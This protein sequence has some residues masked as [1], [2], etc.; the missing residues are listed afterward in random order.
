MSKVLRHF[1]DYVV[2]FLS[3]NKKC[4]RNVRILA[5]AQRK[6]KVIKTKTMPVVT[7]HVEGCGFVTADVATEIGVVMLTHHI[8]G[9]HPIAAP[10]LAVQ[11]RAKVNPPTL[12]FGASGEAYEYF[13]S[14]W[15]VYK[16]TTGITGG[17]AHPAHGTAQPVLDT[18][19]PPL[20]TVLDSGEM[21]EQ[22]AKEVEA[23]SL[24]AI[25]FRIKL[26][27]LP[28]DVGSGLKDIDWVETIAW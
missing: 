15:T 19:L 8:A 3:V 2:H 9:V 16:E 23:G 14:C 21:V 10:G 27:L 20:D 13:I 28:C 6:I 18:V 17:A 11:K 12:D 5:N 4:K 25:N 24:V 7:C 26:Q 1:T 22:A